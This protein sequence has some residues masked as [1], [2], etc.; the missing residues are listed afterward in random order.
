MALIFPFSPE[1]LALP[2]AS[3][4]FPQYLNTMLGGAFRSALAFDAATSEKCR[5]VQFPMPVFSGALTLK[6][7]FAIAAT[8]GNVQFRA[9]IEAITPADALNVNTTTN[10]DTA[11]SSGAVSVP[12]S[13]Y[14]LKE[15]SI[16]LTN[17]D[18]IAAGDM[19]T[20]TLDRDVTV[21]SNAS[22]D[23]YILNARLED[24]S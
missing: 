16:P 9:A 20:F 15:F 13:T 23:C 6:V 22:G 19:V 4:N 24:A 21:S 1:H 12:A 5:S 3:T 18:S 2:A 11:N 17:N 8:S 10:F 14:N 7:Q